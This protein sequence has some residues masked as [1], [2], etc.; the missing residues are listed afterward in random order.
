VGI[1]LRPLIEERRP[2]LNQ[3]LNLSAA[4]AGEEAEAKRRALGCFRQL[5]TE[6]EDILA[7]SVPAIDQSRSQDPLTTYTKAAAKP[8]VRDSTDVQPYR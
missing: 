6:A 5:G 7:R 2:L 4:L 1:P 3:R 8:I